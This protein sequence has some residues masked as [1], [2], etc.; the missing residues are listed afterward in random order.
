MPNPADKLPK[1]TFQLLC[2][3]LAKR[4]TDNGLL[5]EAGWLGLKAV[6]CPRNAPPRQVEDMRTAFFAGA[7]HLFSSIMT[8]MDADRDPTEND[9]RRM[10]QINAELERFY[11]EFAAKHGLLHG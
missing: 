3:E 4:A 10:S 5:I 8:I 11:A 6:A 7:Q 1:D 9:M 2:E